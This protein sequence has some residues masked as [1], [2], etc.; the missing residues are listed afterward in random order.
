[1]KIKS[2][3]NLKFKDAFG[4]YEYANGGLALYEEG[5]GFISLDG[6]ESVYIPRGGRK[7]LKAIIEQGFCGSVD[8][9]QPIT[10]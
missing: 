9:I 10:Q 2:V 1:M 5:K 4:I 8:Y 3:K 7:A 6:G